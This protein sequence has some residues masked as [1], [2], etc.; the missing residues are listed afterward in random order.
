LP[1]GQPAAFA[2]A[3]SAR[4][5]PF[6]LI[7]IAMLTFVIVLLVARSRSG[8]GLPASSM[9]PGQAMSPRL[10]PDVTVQPSA[11]DNQ[12]TAASGA[13]GDPV[14]EAARRAVSREAPNVGL[15]PPPIVS[16]DG[17]VHLRTGGTI[18]PDEYNEARSKLKDSPLLKDPPAPPPF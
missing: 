3:T 11:P 6:L 14:E 4:P 16:P 18:S 13:G 9:Q 17:K 8:S 1:Q 5:H 12:T 2:R 7:G 15:P 10:N